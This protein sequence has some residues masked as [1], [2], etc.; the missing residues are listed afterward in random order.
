MTECRFLAPMRFKDWVRWKNRRSIPDD[1]TEDGTGNQGEYPYG[2]HEDLL[3]TDRIGDLRYLAINGSKSAAL[4]LKRYYSEVLTANP[5]LA[6]KY[7]CYSVMAGDEDTRKE[8]HSG[9]MT[10]T[11]SFS[12]DRPFMDKLERFKPANAE[13]AEEIAF[14][15][16]AARTEKIVVGDTVYEGLS[17]WD[18]VAYCIRQYAEFHEISLEESSKILNPIINDEDFRSG[19]GIVGHMNMPKLMAM[20]RW[21]VEDAGGTNPP[22]RLPKKHLNYVITE[23]PEYRRVVRCSIRSVIGCT[24]CST[25]VLVFPVPLPSIS[26]QRI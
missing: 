6:Y 25:D 4:F 9:G 21:M 10:V 17:F 14:G 26:R 7:S 5:A 13:K 15:I 23:L 1:D 3:Y 16:I 8:L 11:E 18:V 24:G 19:A 20:L 12:E 22:L 2:V